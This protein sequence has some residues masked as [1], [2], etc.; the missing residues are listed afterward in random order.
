MRYRGNLVRIF[1]V[2]LIVWWIFLG[3]PRVIEVLNRVV[4]NFEIRC[5]GE[6]SNFYLKFLCEKLHGQSFQKQM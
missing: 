1:L 2:D 6:V 3:L 4:I 5:L